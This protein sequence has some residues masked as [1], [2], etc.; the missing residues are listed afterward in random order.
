MEWDWANLPLHPIIDDNNDNNTNGRD[1]FWKVFLGPLKQLG[2]EV[3]GPG[4]MSLPS[5]MLYTKKVFSSDSPPQVFIFC[6]AEAVFYFA[7]FFF[8]QGLFE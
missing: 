2:S 8:I 7:F 6:F 1:F 4:N 5:L 3:A